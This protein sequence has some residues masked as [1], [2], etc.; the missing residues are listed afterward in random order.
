[1]ASSLMGN[2]ILEET[3][4]GK[5]KLAKFLFPVSRAVDHTYSMFFSSCLHVRQH[6]HIG[7]VLG[8]R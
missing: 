1:M 7:R 4:S 3:H 8:I 5:H 6:R 2:D